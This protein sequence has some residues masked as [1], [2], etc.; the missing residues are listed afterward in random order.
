MKIYDAVE[1]YGGINVVALVYI[2]H[3]IFGCK[4]A[5]YRVNAHTSSMR[6]L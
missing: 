1:K 2:V 4:A 3:I 6:T 5:L